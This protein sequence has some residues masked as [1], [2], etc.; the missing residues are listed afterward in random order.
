MRIISI[1]SNNKLRKRTG[2]VTIFHSAKLSFNVSDLYIQMH[3]KP[4]GL[5]AGRYMEFK[6]PTYCESARE[7]ELSTRYV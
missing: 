6:L 1:I 2:P 7:K 4:C 5:E 3:G